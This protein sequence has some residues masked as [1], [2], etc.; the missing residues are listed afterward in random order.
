MSTST[1]ESAIL[2]EMTTT[3]HLML[4]AIGCGMDCKLDREFVEK[5]I[6][7]LVYKDEMSTLATLVKTF[8]TNVQ[9]LYWWIIDNMV[10]TAEF[11]AKR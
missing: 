1:V 9:R 6:P 2:K 3:G 8:P 4:V 5:T 11:C 10:L 7:P